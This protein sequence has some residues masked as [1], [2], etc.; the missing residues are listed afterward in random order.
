[1]TIFCTTLSVTTCI[2]LIPEGYDGFLC[3]VTSHGTSAGIRTVDAKGIVTVDELTNRLNGKQ[4]KHLRGKPKLFFIQ[5]CRGRKLDKGVPVGDLDLATDA[6]LD[7][8]MVVPKLPTDADFLICYSTTR[9]HISLRRFSL[10]INEQD[11]G[12]WFIHVL[13]KVFTEYM[14][15]ES[16]MEMMIRVN[17]EVARMATGDDHVDGSKAMPCQMVRLRAKLMLGNDASQ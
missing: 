1:M 12:S 11:M 10:D 14:H 5:A 3:F 13:T 8:E 17:A 7:D 16:V 4:C 9:D 15:K 6:A 2:T